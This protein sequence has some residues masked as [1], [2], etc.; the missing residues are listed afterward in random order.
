MAQSEN[1]PRQGIVDIFTRIDELLIANN[2]F[3]RQL[4]LLLGK[5]PEG[6]Q[7]GLTLPVSGIKMLPLKKVFEKFKP[8]IANT[9]YFPVENGLVDCREAVA[10]LIIVRS[11]CNQA[12]T[13]QTIGGQSPQAD[14]VSAFNIEA[15]QNLAANSS[16]GL[17]V[18]L[19]TNWYPYMGI[20]IASG[21][22]PPTG[23]QVDAWALIRKWIRE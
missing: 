15:A 7:L 21:A 20:S 18:D 8:Y 16:I 4:L 17:G 5:P 12:L 2:E 23:G 19:A 3:L 14:S 10:V 13:I 6:Q 11:T 9:T 1:I 22:A